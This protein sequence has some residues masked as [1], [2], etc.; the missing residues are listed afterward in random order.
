MELLQLSV[1]NLFIRPGQN[2][3]S[4]AIQLLFHTVEDKF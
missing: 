4:L 1:L 3:P 2:A